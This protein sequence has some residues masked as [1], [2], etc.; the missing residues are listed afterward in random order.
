MPPESAPTDAASLRASV[1][2]EALASRF[3]GTAAGVLELMWNVTNSERIE[4]AAA[5]RRMDAA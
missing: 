5:I 4:H 2:G 1:C 3:R